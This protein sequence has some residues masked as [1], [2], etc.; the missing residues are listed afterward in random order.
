M[1]TRRPMHKTSQ[2]HRL[3]YTTYFDNLPQLIQLLEQ[4]VYNYTH[5]HVLKHF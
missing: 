5:W 3:V 1:L 2:G 4:R